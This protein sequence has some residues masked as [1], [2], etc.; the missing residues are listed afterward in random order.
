[1]TA[2][3][4]GCLSKPFFIPLESLPALHGRYGGGESMHP[5]DD[6]AIVQ[7]IRLET[8]PPLYAGKR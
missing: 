5:E 2:D 4:S 3:L 7:Y 6:G 8:E 1:M